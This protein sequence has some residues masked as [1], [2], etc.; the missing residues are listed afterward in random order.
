MFSI[1][2]VN[3]CFSLQ[4]PSRIYPTLAIRRGFEPPPVYLLGRQSFEP[5]PV[6]RGYQ[7]NAIYR[8][9]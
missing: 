7:T 6:Y 5:P 9:G 4:H 3:W 1:V 2:I 8:F